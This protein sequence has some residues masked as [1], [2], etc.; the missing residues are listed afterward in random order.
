MDDLDQP[1][2]RSKN[3]NISP[4]K[5]FWS[6]SLAVPTGAMWFDSGARPKSK[7]QS[8]EG[9]SRAFGVWNRYKRHSRINT[10]DFGCFIRYTSVRKALLDPL[11]RRK[12]EC[13]VTAKYTKYAKKEKTKCPG[14]P[15]D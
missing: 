11:Q 6:S 10:G 5:S 13:G 8:P 14:Q 3:L 4:S 1:V 2:P 12:R 15:F 9:L 7:G